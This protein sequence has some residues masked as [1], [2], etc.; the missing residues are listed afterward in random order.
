MRV[1]IRST[2][3]RYIILPYMFTSLSLNICK[4]QRILSGEEQQ[5]RYKL[6]DEVLSWVTCL[7]P[8]FSIV[9]HQKLNKTDFLA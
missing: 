9:S 1:W 8:W 3:C 2:K 7:T 4:A 5:G 6:R